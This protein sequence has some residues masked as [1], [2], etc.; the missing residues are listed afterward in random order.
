ML[1]TTCAAIQRRADKKT[2]CVLISESC[3]AAETIRKSLQVN[4]SKFLDILTEKI[5]Y[6][7]LHFL[8]EGNHFFNK[9]KCKKDKS[10]N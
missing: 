3:A 1:E 7:M 5:E 6:I 4:M 8:I 9:E 10:K 2:Q